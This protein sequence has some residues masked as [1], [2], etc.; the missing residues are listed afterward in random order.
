[1]PWRSQVDRGNWGPLGAGRPPKDYWGRIVTNW[2]TKRLKLLLDR[3]WPPAKR[4][5]S[6]EEY[7]FDDIGMMFSAA[8]ID[9]RRPDR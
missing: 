8:G 2:I 5:R 9:R 4:P 1:M 3:L 7:I 6:P